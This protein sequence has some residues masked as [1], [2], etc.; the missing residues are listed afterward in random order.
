MVSRKAYQMKLQ[1][2]CWWAV[3]SKLGIT[4]FMPVEYFAI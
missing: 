4:N 2:I 3:F 1:L